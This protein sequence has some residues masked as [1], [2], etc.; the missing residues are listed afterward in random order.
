MWNFQGSIIKGDRMR[1]QCS[2]KQLG[3]TKILGKGIILYYTIFVF[4]QIED[5]TAEIQCQVITIRPIFDKK[6]T[7]FC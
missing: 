4:V 3:Q 2:F 5:P 1:V 6:K 7:P